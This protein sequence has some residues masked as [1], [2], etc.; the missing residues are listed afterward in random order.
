MASSGVEL[1]GKLVFLY[2]ETPRLLHNISIRGREYE[3][4]IGADYLNKINEGYMQF[5]RQAE[6]SGQTSMLIL[7]INRLDFVKHPDHYE[8]IRDAILKDYPPGVHRIEPHA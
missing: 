7:D 1:P 4:N 2:V 6:L 3:Q 5:F 8:I